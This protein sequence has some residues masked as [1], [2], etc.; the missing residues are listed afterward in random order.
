MLLSERHPGEIEELSPGLREQMEKDLAVRTR[1]YVLRFLLKSL[2]EEETTR[3]N[4]ALDSDDQALAESVWNGK[5]Q[6][7]AE[8]LSKFRL[9]YLGSL[10]TE[11]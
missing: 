5:E 7:F 2:S 3:L 4:A 11:S 10:V 1:N 9:V 6:I 8:G